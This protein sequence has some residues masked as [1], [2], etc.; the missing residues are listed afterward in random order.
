MDRLFLKK[1]EADFSYC[2]LGSWLP[3]HFALLSVIQTCKSLLD[4]CCISASSPREAS[5]FLN[6]PREASSD[7]KAT[8][9]M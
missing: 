9:F 2:V 7:V 4:I 6:L 1:I 8:N 5:F 3:G